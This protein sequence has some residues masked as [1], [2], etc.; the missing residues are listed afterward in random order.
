MKDYIEAILHQ[1]VQ[2]LPY[3]K[4]TRLP[5]AYRSGFHFSR[6]FIGGQEA[7]IAAPL[8][9]LSLSILRK[10]HRQIE[11]YTGLPCVL[12][13]KEMNYYSRDAMLE[14]GIPFVWENHQIYL[15][16][17]GTLLDDTKG[18]TVRTCERISYLTQKMLLMAL[19]QGWQRMNVT[20]VAALLGVSKMSVTRCFD[21]MEAMNI[22]YLMIRSRARNISADSDKKMMWET[23]K[24]VLRNPVIASFGLKEEPDI[25]LPMSGTMALAHY[26]M[27]DDEKYPI[28]AI[29]KKNLTDMNI[30]GDK[31]TLAGDAPGCVIQ[32][33][34]YYI[35]FEDSRAVDPLTVALSLS[36][37]ELSDPR[38]SMAVDEMLEEHVW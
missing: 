33:V 19:Y 14:E 34:G 10:Q 32:E 36:E 17:I 8:E 25:M 21:E 11:I 7:L 35:P 1:D 2:I 13:L 4:I 23:I 3:E 20:R 29:T 26:S 22:P 18:K 30:S 16:F 27:L 6:M 9:N 37:D 24:P 31:I 12:Y 15:P 5:L 28:L 38:I